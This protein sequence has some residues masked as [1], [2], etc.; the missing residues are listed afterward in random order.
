MKTYDTERK[1]L[2]DWLLVK[3]AEY[4][5][6]QDKEIKDRGLQRD[7]DSTWQYHYTVMEYNR[8][9]IELKKK[10]GIK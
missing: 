3:T 2:F 8:K 6:R 9:L 7:S 10:Y 1:E 4:E 5:T